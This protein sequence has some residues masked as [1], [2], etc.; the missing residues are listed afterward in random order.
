MGTLKP[1]AVYIY[2]HA[3]GVTYARE[4][5]ADPLT[6]QPIGWEYDPINGHRIDYD[7]RTDDGRPLYEHMREDQLWGNIRRAAKDNPALQEALERAIIIYH[8]SKDD[9]SNTTMYHPV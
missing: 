5:G 6:R 4:I 7:K 2:E 8:L 9:P 3:D 1:G